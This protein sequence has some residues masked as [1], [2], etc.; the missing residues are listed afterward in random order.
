MV[1]I[2]DELIELTSQR[3]LIPFIGAGFSDALKLPSWETM[4]RALC[5]RVKGAVSYDEIAEAT[6]NDFL[7]IAEYLYLKCDRQIG[8]IRHQLENSLAFTSSPVLSPAHVELVNLGAKQIYTTNYDELIESTLR[9]LG[10]QFDSVILPKD[11]AIAHSDRLQVVKYHGDLSHEQTLILT[12]SAY[13]RRLDFESPMDLKFRS[14][15]LGK[16]VL[17]MGYSFRDV[18]I[19]II[20]FKLMEMIRD[21]P[22]ADRHASYIVRISPN[23]V[24]E[25]L[26]SAVGLKTIVLDPEGKASSRDDRSKLLSDFLLD[27]S[28]R[29]MSPELNSEVFVSSAVADRVDAQIDRFEHSFGSRRSAM[30][31]TMPFS[32]GSFFPGQGAYFDRL[33]DGIWAPELQKRLEASVRAYVPF[34]GPQTPAQLARIA[35][36]LGGYSAVSTYVI[37]VIATQGRQE[38]RD[39]KRD[40][41][42]DMP[43]W[44]A[45]WGA[46]QAPEFLAMLLERFESEIKFQASEGIDED[47]A[48]LADLGARI[49]A[50]QMGSDPGKR[51]LAAKLLTRAAEIYPAISELD[52]QADSPPEVASIL[53]AVRRRKA[54]SKRV[55]N[56]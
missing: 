40:L 13:Y 16:S 12:E 47:I 45:I 17:F 1:L 44:S 39:M 8:P 36:R 54:R 29:S 3:R 56:G 14:D 25:D 35:S 28:Q 24:L 37:E 19:R 22:E 7:Q 18:N 27:L 32:I 55:N 6:N 51:Q 5:D 42:K 11:I 38:A 21:I 41:I 33:I 46:T 9:A 4:L 43:D 52:P 34:A 53:D 26:Y 30:R 49:A 15:L 50:G 10:I 20:W 23:P 2:P 48:W 31:L